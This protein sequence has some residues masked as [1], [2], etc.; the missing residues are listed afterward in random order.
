MVDAVVVGGNG[1]GR[2]QLAG[3]GRRVQLLGQMQEM[4]KMK[5]GPR[6]DRWSSPLFPSNLPSKWDLH[7]YI[8]ICHITPKI[9]TFH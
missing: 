6:G 7:L 1:D 9:L 3:V 4:M 8:H 5:I 2:R